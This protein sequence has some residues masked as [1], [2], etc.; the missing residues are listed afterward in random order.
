MRG[1]IVMAMF[2][3]SLAHGA[4]QDFEE[5]RD[6]TLDA[7]DIDEIVVDAGAGSLTVTGVDAAADIVVTAMIR[8]ENRSAE[9]ARTL[10]EKRLHLTLTRDGERAKLVSDIDDGWGGNAVVD[11]D[12]R[13]PADMRLVVDDGSGRTVISDVTGDIRIDDGS[14]SI[15]VHHAGSVHVDDGSGSIKIT[16]SEGDVY[17][18]DGSGTIDIRNVAG[19]VRINDGSGSIRVDNVERDLVIE[20]NGSGSVKFTNVRGSVQQYD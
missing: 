8:I 11:L 6:L 4:R 15:E 20:D 17:V 12:V 1:F 9:E 7:S 19:S 3:V 5:V 14:G 16:D 18:E 13:M 10:I 2:V